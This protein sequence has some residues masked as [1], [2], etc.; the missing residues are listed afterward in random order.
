MIHGLPWNCF[1]L[2]CVRI[3]FSA[4]LMCKKRHRKYKIVAFVGENTCLS[5]VNFRKRGISN[6]DVPPRRILIW[7][8]Y[9]SLTKL[10]MVTTHTVQ[11]F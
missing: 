8:P 10:F 2:M 1:V 4:V 5:T 11:T 7:A 9:F 6:V 3:S